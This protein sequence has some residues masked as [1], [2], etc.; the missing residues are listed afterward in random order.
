MGRLAEAASRL[1]RGPADYARG[2]DARKY[3]MRE[4]DEVLVLEVHRHWFSYWRAAL[5]GLGA[6]LLLAFWS[7]YDT[8]GL[9]LLL[10]AV[11]GAHAG[12]LA[13]EHRR[14]LFVVTSMRVMRLHG[15]LSTKRATVPI[16]RILDITVDKPWH[17]RLIGFGTFIFESAAQEQGLREIKYVGHPDERDLMIQRAV[18]R[19]LRGQ[20]Q[21][22]HAERSPR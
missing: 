7:Q 16:S 11:L 10:A 20:R 5:E 15:V 14:D 12:W 21:E 18:H 2:P 8:G 22:G 19:A 4:M 9:P 3:L 6:L 13:L 17:G 1:W